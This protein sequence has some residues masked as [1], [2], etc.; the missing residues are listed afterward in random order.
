MGVAGSR[1]TSLLHI[2]AAHRPTA[3]RQEMALS[4]PLGHPIILST[5]KASGAV[6]SRPLVVPCGGP[7]AQLAEQLTLNQ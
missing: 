7:L 6:M 5:S 2:N 4:F 1:K 3:L